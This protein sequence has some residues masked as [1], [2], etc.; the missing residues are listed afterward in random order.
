MNCPYCGSSQTRVAETRDVMCG[1]QKRRYR[2]CMSCGER[3]VTYEKVEEK[4]SVKD[5]YG[6]VARLN[7]YH[8][9][10]VI[11]FDPEL[12][13]LFDAYFK[14]VVAEITYDPEDED[15]EL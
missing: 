3:F 15:I 1:K 9:G 10:A 6:L 12:K 2:K 8:E 14:G 13:K 7:K 4:M 5:K 11:G